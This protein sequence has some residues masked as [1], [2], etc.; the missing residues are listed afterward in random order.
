MRRLIPL[1]I[2]LL[3]VVPGCGRQE[4]NQQAIVRL[5]GI[6]TA[7]DGQLQL[8]VRLVLPKLVRVSGGG[9][10]S[11]SKIDVVF[12]ATGR[13]FADA[14][15]RL[16][17]TLPR[18]LLWVH[19]STLILGEAYARQG[20][21]SV[22]DFMAREAEVS[23]D[24]LLVTTNGRAETL[25]RNDPRLEVVL[26]DV[27]EK[28]VGVENVPKV[29]L[30]RFLWT[31]QTA[32]ED[33]VTAKFEVAKEGS[34]R[35][36]GSALYRGDRLV[37]WLS[38]DETRMLLWLRDEIKEETLTVPVAGG[39]V[40]VQVKGDRAIRAQVVG[41]RPRVQLSL[42]AIGE[43]VEASKTI[44]LDLQGQSQIETAVRDHL[45]MQAGRLITTLKRERL[46]PLRLASAVE[47][48]D[49]RGW[50]RLAPDWRATLSALPVQVEAS[51]R[52]VR[53]GRMMRESSPTKGTAGGMRQ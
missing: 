11:S 17:Q 21:H 32:G 48:A 28:L 45:R 35:L 41:G 33:P 47:R 14:A 40:S 18:R 25:L 4:L 8:T 27:F 9:S 1:L 20:I 37:R 6:D 5:I 51:V 36:A 52:L 31:M 12:S 34:L 53:T 50:K 43:L 38:P 22:L 10:G 44:T 7:P 23:L 49:P 24:V 46:D 29:T 26:T 15:A 39:H 3:L 42:H 16:Q 19:A 2:V 30:K 13:T